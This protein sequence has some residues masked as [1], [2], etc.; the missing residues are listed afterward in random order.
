MTEEEPAD[1]R[2]VEWMQSRIPVLDAL[3]AFHP[4]VKPDGTDP[5]PGL[6]REIQRWHQARWYPVEGG[7]FRVLVPKDGR[8]YDPARFT[9]QEG[10][11]DHS[12]CDQCSARISA[13]TLCWVTRRDPYFSF[14][15]A[16]YTREIVRKPR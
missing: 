1:L 7:G 3:C 10:A 9:V 11:W 4:G 12:H 6:T 2:K 16:C 8:S 13:M 14:C 15:A 5:D